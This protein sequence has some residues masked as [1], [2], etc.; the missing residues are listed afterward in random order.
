MK[1]EY[2]LPCIS[3][4]WAPLKATDLQAA[5]VE[6]VGWKAFMDVQIRDAETKER[7]TIP[8]KRNG[9]NVCDVDEGPCNCGAWH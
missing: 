6:I 1:L 7:V 4:K 9:G 5:A 3:F 8:Y 2:R